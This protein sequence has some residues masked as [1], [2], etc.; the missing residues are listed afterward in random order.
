VLVSVGLDVLGSEVVE[1]VEVEPGWPVVTGAVVWSVPPVAVI[2]SVRDDSEPEPEPDMA[3]A[4]GYAQA[5]RSERRP[6]LVQGLESHMSMFHFRIEV[7]SPRGSGSRS[8]AEP[9]GRSRG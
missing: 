4:G 5:V 8:E 6:V 7:G 3:P 9:V 1:V 2:A